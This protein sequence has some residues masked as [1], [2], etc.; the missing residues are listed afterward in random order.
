M[1]RQ[2][3][4]PQLTSSEF[5]LFYYD[6]SLLY[7]TAER[8][9]GYNVAEFIME[10]GAY[11]KIDAELEEIDDQYNRIL[12]EFGYSELVLSEDELREIEKRG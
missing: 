1:R 6:G 8:R 11:L 2:R 10:F 4:T 3:P 7:S 5:D 12:Q 9:A